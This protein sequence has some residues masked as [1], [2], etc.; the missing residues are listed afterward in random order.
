[1]TNWFDPETPRIRGLMFATMLLGLVMASNIPQAFGERG[2]VFAGAY[3]AMQVGRTAFIAAQLPSHHPL[4]S[5]YRR[6][7]GWVSIA[8]VLWIAGGLAR[9]E[10][11]IMFWLA[12]ALC[13][14]VSPMF[15]FALPGMG[16]SRT[17]EWTIEGD[18][19]SCS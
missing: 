5:N 11:R 13:E 9:G 2:L 8:A 14:Y 7:L 16:R 17:M 18:A 10:A 3:A 19:A 15:G 6:M 12:A 1:M 4:A